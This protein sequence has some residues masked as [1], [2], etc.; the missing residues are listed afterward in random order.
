MEEVEARFGC[1]LIEL[2]GMTELSGL[3]STHPLYGRNRHGSIGIALPYTEMRIAS[4]DDAATTLPAGEV[5]EEQRD[6]E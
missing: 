1:P 6:G 2:W 5:G 3:G 4:G